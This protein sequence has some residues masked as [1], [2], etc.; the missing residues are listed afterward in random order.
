MILVAS[1]SA[2]E[3]IALA[4]V[5]TT[6]SINVTW[7][8]TQATRV[9]LSY[10]ITLDE[11]QSLSSDLLHIERTIYNEKELVFDRLPSCT[12]FETSVTAANHFGKSTT[13]RRLI[14][15]IAPGEC[16]MV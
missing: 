5:S 6:N 14:G 16:L 2:I 15:T 12:Q 11:I 3:P 13:I 9:G 10:L 1:T 4:A 7:T 8:D